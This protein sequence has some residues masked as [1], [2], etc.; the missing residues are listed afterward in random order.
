MKN[1]PLDAI[2]AF[3]TSIELGSV[4]SAAEQLGRSQPAISLQIKRLEELLGKELI[5]RSNRKLALSEEGEKIFELC[6]QLLASNDRIVATLSDAELAGQITL[7]I[8]SEFATTLLPSIVG[9]FAQ[10]YP[11]VGLEVFSDLSRNLTAENRRDQYDLI[12]ALHDQHKP[13]RRGLARSDELVWVGQNSTKLDLSSLNQNPTIPLVLAQEGC[14]YRK[15]ALKK[16][17]QEKLPWR[18][19]HTNPDLAGIQAAISAGLGI[20]VLAKST[21]PEALTILDPTRH[22][23]PQ[24]GA[25]D[26]SLQYNRRTASE[27]VDRLAE[28]I[29]SSLL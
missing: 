28:F 11:N 7:G 3:V 23:L 24:L 12:L 1:L 4:S 16:L 26:I 8:P 6:K 22:G 5:I 9:R 20:T 19:V 17:D 15:R 21:V 27:S 10:A 14:L 29:R 25:I 18:I 2:R 13:T